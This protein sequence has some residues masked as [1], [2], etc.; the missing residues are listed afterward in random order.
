MQT[1]KRSDRVLVIFRA[2]NAVLPPITC[3]PNYKLE[4]LIEIK[5]KDQT[6]IKINCFARFMLV[7]EELR[8]TGVK[9]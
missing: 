3:T 9:C 2:T 1:T 6:F 5:L 8:C 4:F 7:C